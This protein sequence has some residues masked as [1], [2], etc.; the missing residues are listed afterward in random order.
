MY[1]PRGRPNPP[2]RQRH[3]TCRAELRVLTKTGYGIPYAQKVDLDN[4]RDPE[5]FFIF[6]PPR[7]FVPIL[8]I[9]PSFVELIG[10]WQVKR[11]RIFVQSTHG[12]IW[13]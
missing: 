1:H 12:R 11:W 6:I 8:K 5:D 9:F 10:S 13:L 3:G 7:R 2:V 4:P